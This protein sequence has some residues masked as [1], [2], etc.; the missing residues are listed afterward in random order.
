MEIIKTLADEFKLKPDQVER[1]VALIDDGCTI[2]FIA[3]YRKEITG[4]LDD[5]L[6]RD[7]FDRLTYLRSLE[8]RKAEVRSLIEEQGKLTPEIESELANAKILTEVEDI[9]RPFRPKRRTRASVAR[10]RGLEPLAEAIFM[11]EE[12]YDPGLQQMAEA[13]IDPEKEV[14]TAEDAFAG[15]C[16]IIAEDISDNAEFRKKIRALTFDYGEL[17]SK[18]AKEGDSVYALYYDFHERLSKIPKHRIL[19]INRGEKE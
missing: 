6:L 16:D 13:L 11:Q 3:R 12:S 4:S 1:T 2:P 14:M 19:A 7:L 8:S 15:A 17:V 18:Q 5:S 10:E 9:Y